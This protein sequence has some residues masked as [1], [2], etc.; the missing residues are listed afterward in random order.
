MAISNAGE[1]R[2]E[3]SDFRG[4]SWVRSA[5]IRVQL[6]SW[7]LKSGVKF[8][9]RVNPQN[10]NRKG[11]KDLKETKLGFFAVFAVFVV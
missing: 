2:F 7:A 11:L 3:D 6:L 8:K 10:A 4:P 9:V 5:S 1:P